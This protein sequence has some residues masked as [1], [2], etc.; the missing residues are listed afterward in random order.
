M[1]FPVG[2]D[3]RDRRIRPLVNYALVALNVLVFVMLQD[4]G[5]NDK[6]TFAFSTV[7]AE[8]VTGKDIV[9]DDQVI[10][11]PVS[12]DRF[13]I[14]GLKPSPEPVYIT[15]LTSMF[16]HGGIAHIFG[17][18][19]FLLVFGD[20]IENNRQAFFVR[21]VYGEPKPLF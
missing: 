10:T 18:M 1:L 16:M 5:S 19:I 8:I 13:R 20:N 9:T 14:S 4:L 7:P 2:D 11:D 15:L 17:N 3:N 12:G 21:F 6:F